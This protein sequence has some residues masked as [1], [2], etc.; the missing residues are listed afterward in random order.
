MTKGNRYTG[1]RVIDTPYFEN[2]TLWL[3]V[4]D[5]SN[6]KTRRYIVDAVTEYIL[7]KGITPSGNTLKPYWAALNQAAQLEGITIASLIEKACAIKLDM[8]HSIQQPV[9]VN[10]ND[11][12]QPQEVIA[13]VA[14]KPTGNI[15]PQIGDLFGRRKDRDV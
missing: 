2:W 3:N 5:K 13:P 8:I 9:R 14:P 10:I 1:T 6:G 15:M 4:V 12:M 7:S 11:N